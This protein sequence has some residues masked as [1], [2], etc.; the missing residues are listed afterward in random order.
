MTPDNN[1]M[2]WDDT[3]ENDGQELVVLPEGNY[4]FT[5]THFERGRFPGSPKIPPCNKATLTVTIDNDQGAAMARVDLILYRTLEWK[6]AAFFRC[7]GQKKLGEKVVMDWSKVIGARGRAHF[8]P[9]TY[10]KNGE[11]RQVNDVDRFLDYDPSVAFTEVKDADLP[12]SN[13]G[14]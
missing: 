1:I 8:K 13:G 5:V 3:I 9:R 6:I 12:W 2:N 7:I 11:E 10:I 4:T 14:F